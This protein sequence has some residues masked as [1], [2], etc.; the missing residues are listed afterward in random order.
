MNTCAFLKDHFCCSLGTRLAGQ[1]RLVVL[2]IQWG[3]EN[4][5]GEHSCNGIERSGLHLDFIH[6][7]ESIGLD[8]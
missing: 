5:L 4:A 6:E 1:V 7:K 2:V 8:V 3:D